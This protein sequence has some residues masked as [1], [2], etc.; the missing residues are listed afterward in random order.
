MAVFVDSSFLIALA[1]PRDPW[2]EAARALHDDIERRR[3]LHIHA[4]AV[5]EVVAAVGSRRGGKVAHQ[6]Y[7]AMRDDMTLH[8]PAES[9][10]DLAMD[11]VVRYDGGLS[12]SDAYAV[13]LIQREE[14]DGVVSFDDDFDKAG[15]R[16]LGA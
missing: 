14:W 8:I 7:E 6:A 15:L 16:R 12:L 4:L 10:L 2:H 11:L 1:D 9:D 5:A 3:P 13:L